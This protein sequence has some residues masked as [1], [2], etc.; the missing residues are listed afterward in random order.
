MS[1]TQP[2]RFAQIEGQIINGRQ[3]QHIIE[4]QP[5]LFTSIEKPLALFRVIEP[6]KQRFFLCDSL[7]WFHSAT[8]AYV[9]FAGIL[10]GSAT[11]IAVQFPTD[12]PT[13]LF[14]AVSGDGPLIDD[15]GDVVLDANGNVVSSGT[16]T[17]SGYA[18]GSTVR[19]V[20]YDI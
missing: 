13:T 5:S 8:E 10:V 9:A 2:D 16:I 18:I 6:S 11:N 3:Y 20:A 19:G 15:D 7:T 12:Y 17:I 4:A 14:P 1:A